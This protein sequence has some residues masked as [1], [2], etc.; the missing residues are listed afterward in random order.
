MSL[1]QFFLT[2]PLI[3]ETYNIKYTSGYSLNF[4]THKTCTRKIPESEIER[5]LYLIKPETER[6]LE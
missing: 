1:I 4:C 6:N 3:Y 5:S 2:T